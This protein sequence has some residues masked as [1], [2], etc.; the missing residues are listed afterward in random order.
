VNYQYS[1]GNESRLCI[2]WLW[3]QRNLKQIKLTEL[4]TKKPPEVQLSFY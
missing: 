4:L 2:L 3:N 1:K